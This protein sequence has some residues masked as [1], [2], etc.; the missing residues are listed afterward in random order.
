MKKILGGAIL[1]L[2][3]LGVAIFSD[4]E[5]AKAAAWD[6]QAEHSVVSKEE[7]QKAI[8][9]LEQVAPDALENLPFPIENLTLEKPQGERNYEFFL[10]LI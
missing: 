10:L 3:C 5:V 2:V 8:E 1:S 6:G 9:Y 7:N 4:S